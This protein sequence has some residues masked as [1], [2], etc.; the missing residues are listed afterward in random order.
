MSTGIAEA[1][2]AAAAAA[3][4]AA[5]ADLAAGRRGITADTLHRLRDDYRHAQLSAE[6]AKV[7]AERAREAARLAA[8]GEVG[9]QVDQ[10]AIADVAGELADV[11]QVITDACARARSIT[12]AWDGSVRDL[13]E[14]ACDLGVSDAPP[15]GPA[16]ASGYLAARNLGGDQSITHHRVR[17]TPVSTDLARA[18]DRA[19]LGH[20]DDGLALIAGVR[21]LPEPKRPDLVVRGRGGW[22]QP[23]FGELNEN[24][25]SQVRTGDL[26][27]LDN[28]EVE[29][30]L[31]GDLK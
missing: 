30:W 19:V 10:L 29:A 11:L 18:I 21:E 5:E 2:Q 16:K 1:D 3:V 4:G 17:L 20:P 31:R 7:K 14:A 25:R 15:G 8:L 22:C 26:K 12:G 9:R 28:D 23:I 27:V 24:Q 13:I 6:G